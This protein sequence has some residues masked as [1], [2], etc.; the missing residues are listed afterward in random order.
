MQCRFP[1]GATEL[2]QLHVRHYSLHESDLI[3]C[4]VCNSQT[5]AKELPNS[6]GQAGQSV[7]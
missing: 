4:Q 6:H 5:R 3:A 2:Y 1:R 7:A